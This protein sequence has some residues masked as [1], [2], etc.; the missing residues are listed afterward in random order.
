MVFTGQLGYLSP[1]ENWTSWNVSP[2]NRA[3]AVKEVSRLLLEYGIPL[4][5][6]FDDAGGAVRHLRTHGAKFNPHMKNDSLAPLPFILCFGTNDDAQE[7]FRLYVEACTYK[8]RIFELFASLAGS[9]TVDLNSSE[10][11]QANLV[12]LAYQH[13]LTLDRA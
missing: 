3:A 6:I 10:F 8:D 2:A 7:F 11:Y 4:F 1:L 9:S 13:G 12:K 5:R